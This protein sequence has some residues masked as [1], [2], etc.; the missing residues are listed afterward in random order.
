[1]LSDLTAAMKAE[2]TDG[3][4]S[5]NQAIPA[6]QNVAGGRGKAVA[7]HLHQCDQPLDWAMDLRYVRTILGAP[8]PWTTVSIRILGEAPRL[9][10]DYPRTARYHVLA[11]SRR[12]G[13]E[14]PLLIAAE[15]FL[16][17][18]EALCGAVTLTVDVLG[19]SPVLFN[20]KMPITVAPA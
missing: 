7:L 17:A 11:N 10:G 14:K 4:V 3:F 18:I 12:C 16:Q 8:L 1:M 2:H 13:C 6:I 20:S 19:Y 15:K 5:L 9:T